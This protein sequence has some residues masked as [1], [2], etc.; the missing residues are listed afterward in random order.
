MTD[1]QPDALA[2]QDLQDRARAHLAQSAVAFAFNV[3][4]QELVAPTRRSP[5]AAF[6]RQVAMYL[7]HITFELPLNRVAM[8]FGRDRSTAAY[9]CHKIEDERDDRDFDARLD[10]LEECLR[11]APEPQAWLR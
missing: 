10:A 8:A 4:P 2:G 3:S 1:M 9:A 11:C 5:R 7:A 6:A